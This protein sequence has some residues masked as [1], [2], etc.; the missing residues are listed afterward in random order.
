MNA[1]LLI[2][3]LNPDPAVV[4]ADKW[5]GPKSVSRQPCVN[6]VRLILLRRGLTYAEVARRLG[7]SNR[8]SI[9]RV[10]YGHYRVPE[11]REG[12][13]KLVNMPVEALWPE[14]YAS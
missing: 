1:S 10:V 12:I 7:V 8:S 4:N 9:A 14:R 5:P 11:I 13:A 6:R 2:P 3:L